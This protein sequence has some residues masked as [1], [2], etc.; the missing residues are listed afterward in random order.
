MAVVE[1]VV[2]GYGQVVPLVVELVFPT[3]IGHTRQSEVPAILA[4]CKSVV[5]HLREVIPLVGGGERVFC[6]RESHNQAEK[7]EVVHRV[8]FI[9]TAKGQGANV[10]VCVVFGG[11]VAG[12]CG[13]EPLRS[14]LTEYR[15]GLLRL[16]GRR[17]AHSQINVGR[18][19]FV[20]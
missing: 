19:L 6:G 11:S 17:A 1:V 3:Q 18:E 8:D 20:F 15:A 12:G 4:V 9:T 16:V 7:G 13:V 2:E 14:V 10:A 5:Q